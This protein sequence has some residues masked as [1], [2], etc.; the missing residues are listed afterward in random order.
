MISISFLLEKR[1]GEESTP[2]CG[3]LK[4]TRRRRRFV[5]SLSKRC[6]ASNDRAASSEVHLYTLQLFYKPTSRNLIAT[7]PPSSTDRSQ[8]KKNA[9]LVLPPSLPPSLLLVLRLDQLLLPLHS[10]LLCIA[11]VVRFSLVSARILRIG[12]R[13][14]QVLL[15]SVRLLR[16]VVSGL[17]VLRRGELCLVVLLGR[18]VG[19]VGRA[20][21]LG[22]SGEGGQVEGSDSE[23]REGGSREPESGGR[24]ER[25][26]GFVGVD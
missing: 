19:H 11:Y 22:G 17:L 25:H 2:I 12:V 9:T 20:V 13:G 8:K 6:R 18:R 4:R 1:A 23:G 21:A 14:G 16:S 26:R 3:K 24:E 7:V 15:A 10:T 5:F